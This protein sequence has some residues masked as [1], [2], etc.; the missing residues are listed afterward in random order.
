MRKGIVIL[1]LSTIII[2]DKGT[3]IHRIL[4]NEFP[5]LYNVNGDNKWTSVRWIRVTNA[6]TYKSRI[7]STTP[8]QVDC[9]CLGKGRKRS[10]PTHRVI[11]AIAHTRTPRTPTH[12][13]MVLNTRQ[14]A[15]LSRLLA[16]WLG[17]VVHYLP[18][19]STRISQRCHRTNW[20]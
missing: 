3:I 13:A 1:P 14:F 17:L 2:I 10:N 18:A 20:T 11:C 6:T 8:T 15:H 4:A 12:S 9:A 5:V 7:C 19:K 16:R